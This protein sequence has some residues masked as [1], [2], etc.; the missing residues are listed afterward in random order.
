MDA[1][2]KKLLDDAR[3]AIARVAGALSVPPTEVIEA[4]TELRDGIDDR[5]SA[6][7]LTDDQEDPGGS[8]D[9]DERD[10]RE[11]RALEDDEP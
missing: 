8:I 9:D 11:R 3:A 5:L 2:L 7:E 10:D 4:L 6:L 1:K